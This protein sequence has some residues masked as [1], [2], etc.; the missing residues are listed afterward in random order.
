MSDVR[1]DIDQV[2]ILKEQSTAELSADP[3]GCIGVPNRTS[4]DLL[5]LL[6]GQSVCVHLP[7]AKV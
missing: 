2:E 6:M 5:A 3:L 7:L 4:L 1:D